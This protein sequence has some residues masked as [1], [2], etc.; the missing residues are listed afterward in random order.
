[1]KD[2]KEI[3][4]LHEEARQLLHVPIYRLIWEDLRHLWQGVVRF[5][6]WQGLGE[7]LQRLVA[8]QLTAGKSNLEYRWE[9]RSTIV[10]TMDRV[11]P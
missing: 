3:N 10:L 11:L 7:E 6:H 8:D 1:M 9:N 5:Q 4:C 2:G